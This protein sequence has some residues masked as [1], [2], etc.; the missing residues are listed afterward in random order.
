MKPIKVS[1][2]TAQQIIKWAEKQE[3]KFDK[4]PLSEI[5]R[6]EYRHVQRLKKDG[7]R[8]LKFYNRI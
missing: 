8:A 4:T 1:K 2:A 6:V 3:R 7:E 5:D